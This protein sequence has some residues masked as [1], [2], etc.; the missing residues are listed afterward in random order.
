MLAAPPTG[1]TLDGLLAG[2]PAAV[3]AGEAAGAVD[4]RAVEPDELVDD[5]PGGGVEVDDR[6]AADALGVVL[7]V[8]R[9]ADGFDAG[10][11]AGCAADLLVASQPGHVAARRREGG[12]AVVVAGVHAAARLQRRPRRTEGPVGEALR[13]REHGRSAVARARRAERS[14]AAGSGAGRKDVEHAGGPTEDGDAEPGG[15]ATE[16]FATGQGHVLLLQV[17]M[18]RS[19][20]IPLG[21]GNEPVADGRAAGEVTTKSDRS[22]PSRPCV[23]ARTTCEVAVRERDG[24]AVDGPITYHDLD[25]IDET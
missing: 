7:G 22:E 1:R 6:D 23:S 11:R 21:G 18:D 12:H 24:A 13:Q 5:L 3:V 16:E 19:P 9:S 20:L 8:G 14:V 10:C 2:D 4:D 15:R 17:P 25:V